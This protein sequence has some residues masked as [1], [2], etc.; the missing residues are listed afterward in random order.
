MK[1]GDLK[2]LKSLLREV[3]NDTKRDQAGTKFD[4]ICGLLFNNDDAYLGLWDQEVLTQTA[5]LFKQKSPNPRAFGEQLALL[6]KRTLLVTKVNDLYSRL[7]ISRCS[8]EDI[9][10]GLSALFNGFQKTTLDTHEYKRYGPIDHPPG[11]NLMPSMNT[12][13]QISSWKLVK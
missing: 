9:A 8:V 10:H 11:K 7:L 1:A 4:E 3:L 6:E 2:R 5:K 12:F 13:A